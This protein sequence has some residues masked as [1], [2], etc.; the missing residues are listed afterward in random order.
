MTSAVTENQ[1]HAVLYASGGLERF[2]QDSPEIEEAL[3]AA[4]Y[5]PPKVDPAQYSGPDFELWKP[6]KRRVLRK[7]DR[8]H[9]TIRYG[10]FIG[11]KIKLDTDNGRSMQLDLLGQ[12][13][14]GLFVLELKVGKSAERNAFSEMFAYSNYIAE[15]FAL[16]GSKDITNVLVANLDNEITTQAYLYDLLIADRD[17]I[18]YRPEFPT[19][20]PSDLKLRLHIP[21]DKDFQHLTNRLLSHDSLD[22]VVVSFH[23]MEDWFDSNED[24]GSLNDY[25]QEHLTAVSNYAA[26]LMEAE[27]L[28]GFCF[29]RKRWKEIP[30]Y[31]RNSLILCAINPFRIAGEVRADNFLKQL[32]EKHHGVF[33]EIP[34]LGFSDRLASIAK[35]V[36]KDSLTHDYESELEFP[37]WS[38]MVT[39]FV[40]VVATHNFGFRPTGILREAFSGYLNMIYADEAAGLCDEDISRLK[41][42]ELFS[43]F[44]AWQFMEQFGFGDAESNDM[45]FDEDSQSS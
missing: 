7:I 23:D 6:V 4:D 22:C 33:F 16:S 44:K 30:S 38:S 40:E 15:M 21:A 20:S 8:L 13:E 36:I 18:V 27:R 5:T 14:P 42:N 17:V 32:D 35:R 2:V 37:L 11:S 45:E 19:S 39:S 28:H 41:I 34:E 31:Y 10:E 12:H 9:R 26:Q 29:V 3:Q 1:V 43:W 25:T 24:N